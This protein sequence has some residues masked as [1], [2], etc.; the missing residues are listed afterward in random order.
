MKGTSEDKSMTKLMKH[1]EKKSTKQE[2]IKHQQM[3]ASLAS[4]KRHP[5][6]YRTHPDDQLNHI[7]QSIREHGIYRNIVVAK[8]MT[9]LAGHGVAEAA[10]KLGITEVPIVRLDIDANDTRALKLLAGDNEISNL[11]EVDDRALTELLK[12]IKVEDTEF[13][14]LGTGFDDNI[15]AGLVMVTRT[16]SEIAGFNAAA[17]WV[18]L[19]DYEDGTPRPKVI[20]S[21]ADEKKRT[22]FLERIG[23]LRKC[24]GSDITRKTV[25]MRWPIEAKMDTKKVRFVSKKGKKEAQS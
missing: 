16:A 22:R 5:K 2:P 12:S 3:L 13:G 21:F 20:I 15:L 11:G 23:Y 10:R 18:G 25:A 19:T 7:M 6:N 9:I 4:L 14:L 17:E 8:D 1:K 24:P